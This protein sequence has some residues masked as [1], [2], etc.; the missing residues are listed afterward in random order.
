MPDPRDVE[1][2]APTIRTDGAELRAC[3]ACSCPLIIVPGPNGKRIPLDARS[4]T[5]VV[6]SD[7]MGHAVAE[8]APN[9]FVSHFKTC[10]SANEFSKGKKK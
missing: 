5:Y 1:N 10:S 6:K 4:Q 7:L 2:E 8:L 3:K 9:T